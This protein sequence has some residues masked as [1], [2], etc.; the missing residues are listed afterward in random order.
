MGRASKT[1]PPLTAGA[2][3]PAVPT[4]PPDGAALP[5]ALA[6]RLA[7]SAERA[8]EAPDAHLE[9]LLGPALDA[10]E[11]RQPSKTQIRIARGFGILLTTLPIALLVY[12]ALFGGV[13]FMIFLSAFGLPLAS[14][15]LAWPDKRWRILWDSGVPSVPD[16]EDTHWLSDNSDYSAP[17]WGGSDAGS[18][19]AYGYY[20]VDEADDFMRRRVSDA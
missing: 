14:W 15:C 16:H 18:V 11:E 20:A 7:A 17:I 6:G 3:A 9:R 4:L 5:P 8:G 12:E 10:E 1:D 19:G 2:Q 13:A